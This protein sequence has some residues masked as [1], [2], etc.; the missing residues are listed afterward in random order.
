MLFFES[1]EGI[2]SSSCILAEREYNAEKM[3][4][5]DSFRAVR[6]PLSEAWA[7]YVNLDIAN[8][9]FE[10][11]VD[12]D[13]GLQ[14]DG[15]Y[16]WVGPFPSTSKAAERLKSETNAKREACLKIARDLGHIE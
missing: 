13:S 6:I 15:T 12:L 4:Y 10:D 14:D 9:G 7:M 11:W 8:M 3:D 2:E 16:K 1:N 5:D